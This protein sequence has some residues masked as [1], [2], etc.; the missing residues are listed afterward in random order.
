[1]SWN[2][3]FIVIEL[4]HKANPQSSS[5]GQIVS[6]QQNHY[7]IMI[8]NIF[9][10]SLLFI[11]TKL[12][13]N[14]SLYMWVSWHYWDSHSEERFCIPSFKLNFSL[15]QL[16]NTVVIQLGDTFIIIYVQLLD[17]CANESNLVLLEVISLFSYDETR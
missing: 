1:M 16:V 17:A 11:E 12:T 13:V 5:K 6:E 14:R 2:V 9:V 15:G 3:F 7:V 10:I 8:V 4:N